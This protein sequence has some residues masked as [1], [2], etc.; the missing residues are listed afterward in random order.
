MID[1]VIQ[2]FLDGVSER[3]EILLKEAFEAGVRHANCPNETDR[4]PS[5][6]EWLTIKKEK[7]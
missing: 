6:E 3:I 1:R 5:F 4:C 7:K 2:V